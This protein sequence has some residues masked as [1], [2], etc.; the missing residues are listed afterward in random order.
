MLKNDLENEK[1]WISQLKNGDKHAFEVIYSHYCNSIYSKI[2]KMTKDESIAD[3]LL[4]DIFVKIWERKESIVEE[5]SFKG[6]IYKIAENSVFDYYRKLSQDVK[7]R[8]QLIITFAEIYEQTEDYLFDQERNKILTEAIQ[9]LPTQRQIIFKL[10][11]L[12]GKSY[13]EVAEML[14]IS[15]STV[16]GQ[17]VKAMKAIKDH[18]FYNSREFLVF[19]LAIYFRNR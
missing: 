7:L 2:L 12:D 6:W 10:C 4:Q 8:S 9:Q 14:G 5:Y 16:S 15:S 3:D 18:V 1:Q 19:F 11:K 17:M 13:A